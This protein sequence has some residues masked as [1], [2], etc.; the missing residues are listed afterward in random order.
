MKGKD[1][2]EDMKKYGDNPKSIGGGPIACLWLG[3]FLFFPVWIAGIVW[4][5]MRAGEKESSATWGN[6]WFHTLLPL[7]IAFAVGFIIGLAEIS[8]GY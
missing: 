2:S 4:G 7:G 6:F 3:G 1:M 5:A 8:A